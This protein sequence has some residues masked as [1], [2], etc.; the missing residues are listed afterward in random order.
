MAAPSEELADPTAFIITDEHVIV[1]AAPPADEVV[2]ST[3]NE[4]T[5]SHPIS[6]EVP[7]TILEEDV[8]ETIIGPDGVEVVAEGPVPTTPAT[9]DF[10]GEE[11]SFDNIDELTLSMRASP[12]SPISPNHNRS[13]P[14]SVRIRFL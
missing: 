10:R 5:S 7:D 13:G 11:M 8:K 14:P 9:G 1:P 12:A 2:I 6:H 3:I 4:E